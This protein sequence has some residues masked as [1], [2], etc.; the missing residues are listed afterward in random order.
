M[1]EHVRVDA[2]GPI[3]WIVLNRPARR[4]ALTVAMWDSLRHAAER[5]NAQES[6]RLV[7]LSGAGGAFCSGNDI[8]M[9]R[10]NLASADATRAFHRTIDT[11]LAAIRGIAV[12]TIAAVSGACFGAGLS[13]AT[14]CDLRMAAGD[15]TFCVPPAKLGLVYGPAETRLLVQC[16]GPARAKELIYTARVVEAGEALAI[17]LVER[18]AQGDALDAAEAWASE[19]ARLSGVTQRATKRIVDEIA[20]GVRDQG[21]MEELRERAV[22]L[23]DFKEGRAAFME[24][25]SPRFS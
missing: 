11:T 14:A 1:N 16:V 18:V 22:D 7:I 25:R 3:C 17:G 9:L 5:V 6:I 24:K 12:P 10:E 4:N 13:L 8:E 2:E 21:W 20:L 15:A 19:M 23:A